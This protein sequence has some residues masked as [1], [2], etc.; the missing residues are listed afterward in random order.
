M[1]SAASQE[2][3]RHNRCVISELD[4]HMI[5]VLESLRLDITDLEMKNF[6]TE[7]KKKPFQ[8]DEQLSVSTR[9]TTKIIVCNVDEIRK[10]R[11]L[12]SHINAL[13]THE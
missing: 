11:P 4:A 13:C 12:I 5:K 3:S 2:V 9:V 6:I 1:I 8:D 10:P 7:V